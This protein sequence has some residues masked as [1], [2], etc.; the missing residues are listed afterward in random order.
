MTD[1]RLPI[2]CD[3]KSLRELLKTL[4]ANMRM[5]NPQYPRITPSLSVSDV[6]NIVTWLAGLHWG[7]KHG[8]ILN[9]ASWWHHF[10]NSEI[11]LKWCLKA[12]R[13][14]Y[15]TQYWGKVTWPTLK[16]NGYLKVVSIL[17]VYGYT[18]LT[19]TFICIFAYNEVEAEECWD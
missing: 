14:G 4:N 19:P 18:K 12:P 10:F 2:S 11:F 7:W 5:G 16:C 13:V 6:V 17:A 8:Y 15:F 1:T 9:L 3:F